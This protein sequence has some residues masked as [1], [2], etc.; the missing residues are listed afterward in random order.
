MVHSCTSLQTSEP[1]GSVLCSSYITDFIETMIKCLS[2]WQIK[3]SLQGSSFLELK[4]WGRE[5]RSQWTRAMVKSV[6]VKINRD[7]CFSLQVKPRINSKMHIER[8]NV[9]ALAHKAQ[10]LTESSVCVLTV[11]CKAPAVN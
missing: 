6:V 5:K 2:N 9:A 3:W 11:Q 8:P 10:E 7:E 1:R 4:N